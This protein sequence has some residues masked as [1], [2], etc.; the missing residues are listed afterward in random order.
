MERHRHRLC[1][2]DN[3]ASPSAP[4]KSLRAY[5]ASQRLAPVRRRQPRVG[6]RRTGSS[7]RSPWW[8]RL[9]IALLA[10]GMPAGVRIGE[11]PCLMWR[12]GGNSR[13]SRS[14]APRSCY[15]DGGDGPLHLAHRSLAQL[16][17]R[18]SLPCCAGSATDC[19]RSALPPASPPSW[20]GASHLGRERATQLSASSRPST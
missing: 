1:G 2:P 15:P 19:R 18:S 3:L 11:W 16:G 12:A 4:G 8:L 20:R 7:M 9:R 5:A 17:G 6:R 10:S 14:S 13:R